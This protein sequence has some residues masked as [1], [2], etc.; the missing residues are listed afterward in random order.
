MA[1]A[2]QASPPRADRVEPAAAVV[3]MEP[4]TFGARDRQHRQ[5]FVVV[6]LRARMPDDGEVASGE[7]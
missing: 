5:R 6:H 1:V 2:E 7:S 4:R 3:A